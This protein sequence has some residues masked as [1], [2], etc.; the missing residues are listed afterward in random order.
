[1][2]SQAA[3]ATTSKS[4]L[5]F[6]YD[7]QGRRIQKLVSTNSGSGYVGQYTN[8]F[9]YDGWNLLGTIAPGSVLL[10]SYSW[11]VDLSGTLQGAGGVGGLLWVGDSS[12][13]NNQRS[14]HFTANDG[15]GNVAALVNAADGTA[16]AQY[17]YGPFGE[18][19]RATGPMAKA[20]P[21]RFSTKYQDDET[22]QLYYGYRFYNTSTGRWLSRD[23][24]NEDGGLDLYGIVANNLANQV[25]GLGLH[26]IFENESCQAFNA[27]YTVGWPGPT[28]GTVN[29]GGTVLPKWK[30]GGTGS[31]SH[32]GTTIWPFDAMCN[33]ET[34]V[35]IKA[36]NHKSECGCTRYRVTCSWYYFGV[37][38]GG[39]TASLHVPITFL[40]RQIARLFDRK[41]GTHGPYTARVFGLGIVTD[42][43]TVPIGGTIDVFRMS[44]RNNVIGDPK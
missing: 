7:H 37:A 38:E 33:T 28:F 6:A 27:G 8:R 9:I 18:L 5:E 39:D 2:E 11:G 21:F 13:T 17:E 25:D 43:V 14:T 26:L 30:P 19:L 42:T 31:F 36:T 1:M 3:A 40:G 22:D 41:K 32:A 29:L 23:L 35:S 24:I 34:H 10:A 12:T 44:P 4:K 20:N 16:S 15:N